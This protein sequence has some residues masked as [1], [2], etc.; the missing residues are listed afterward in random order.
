VSSKS[1]VVA[2]AISPNG[3]TGAEVVAGARARGS[4]R[5]KGAFRVVNGTTGNA[6]LL[7]SLG[8]TQLFLLQP[9][10]SAS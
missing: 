5:M 3:A 4:L 1:G 6:A 10:K 9:V 7:A 8:V 2:F